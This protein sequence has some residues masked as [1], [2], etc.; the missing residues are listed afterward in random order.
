MNKLMYHQNTLNG[1]GIYYNDDVQFE[2]D[3]VNNVVNDKEGIYKR[4]THQDK[5]E[6]RGKCFYSERK[7]NYE[8]SGRIK[9]KMGLV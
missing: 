6:G 9:I 4:Q 8:G 7:E 5:I 1:Y 3:F 2:G